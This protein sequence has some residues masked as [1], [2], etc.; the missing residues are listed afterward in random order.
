MDLPAP[1]RGYSVRSMSAG[2]STLLPSTRYSTTSKRA[3]AASS[4]ACAET[5]IAQTA[6]PTQTRLCSVLM[7]PQRVASASL[8]TRYR[9]Q[10]E[11]GRLAP[12]FLRTT[13]AIDESISTA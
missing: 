2:G 10:K 6:A 3:G 4:A 5:A 8:L 7:R 9:K 11:E 13:Q 12:A 1:S